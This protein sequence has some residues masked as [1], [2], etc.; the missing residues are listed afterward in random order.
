MYGYFVT[1]ARLGRATISGRLTVRARG[2]GVTPSRKTWLPGVEKTS[3]SAKVDPSVSDRISQI[4]G[5]PVLKRRSVVVGRAQTAAAVP[6][7]SNY[8]HPPNRQRRRVRI[9][10]HICGG[11]YIAT[12]RNYGCSWVSFAPACSSICTMR[13]FFCCV[14][15]HS[16]GLDPI[17]RLNAVSPSLLR[18]VT[19]T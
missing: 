11:E 2:S 4:K 12:I 6:A 1:P 14:N 10:Q 9:P 16:D 5:I 17:T 15:P 13:H 18:R 3:G 19:S 8:R 7:A